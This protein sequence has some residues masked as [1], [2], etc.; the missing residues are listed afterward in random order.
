MNCVKPWKATPYWRREGPRDRNRRQNRATPR[1]DDLPAVHRTTTGPR[2]WTRGIGPH[3][4]VRQMPDLAP[5]T[6]AR[7]AA[8]DARNAGRRRGAAGAYRGISRESPAVFA[9]DL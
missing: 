5:R 6:G 1:R 2:A 8:V 4:G 7:I 9:M 3:A